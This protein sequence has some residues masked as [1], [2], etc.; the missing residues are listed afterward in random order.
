[1]CIMKPLFNYLRSNYS[2]GLLPGFLKF[3]M[4][5]DDTHQGGL[6]QQETEVV[7]CIIFPVLAFNKL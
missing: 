1:M 3:E 6:Y 2:R 5:T 7:P 4:V